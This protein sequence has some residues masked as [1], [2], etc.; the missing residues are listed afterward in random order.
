MK[1]KWKM[2][3]AAIAA[4]LVCGIA[5]APMTAATAAPQGGSDI[6]RQ[7]AE[8]QRVLERLNE[9]RSRENSDRLSGQIAELQAQLASLRELRAQIASLQE[10]RGQLA[11]LQ[12]VKAQ[13]S[14][15]KDV[16]A[17]LAALQ[18]SQASRRGG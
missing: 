1:S 16:R 17:Q 3:R 7:I 5:V 12:E 15:L 6:D 8:Q 4:A 2:A 13:L 9:Q 14:S 10:M 18:E 11:S